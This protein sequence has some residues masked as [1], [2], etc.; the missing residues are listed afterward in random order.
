MGGRWPIDSVAQTP[1]QSRRCRR[2][3]VPAGLI[4]SSRRLHIGRTL[5]I[6]PDISGGVLAL[7]K[8][9]IVVLQGTTEP[10]DRVV[11]FVTLLF[12]LLA[13]ALT[14]TACQPEPQE[15]TILFQEAE[16]LYKGGDF[17]GASKRYQAF[18]RAYPRSPLAETARMRLRTIDREV[19]S[20]MGVKGGNRPIYIRPEPPREAEDL[21][22][23]DVP[24]AN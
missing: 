21:P 1:C 3:S 10:M 17:D 7:V 18:L 12:F 4:A 14:V 24:D 11:R 6:L 16:T 8:S 15:E 22:P 5:P 23:S 19:E 9:A 20:V 13:A 2:T